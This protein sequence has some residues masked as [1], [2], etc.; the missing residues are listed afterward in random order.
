[1]KHPL[2]ASLL[3]D[4]SASNDL[5]DFLEGQ[6]TLFEHLHI[7]AALQN[8]PYRLSSPEAIMRVT[9]TGLAIME[10]RH[11]IIGLFG[12][13]KLPSHAVGLITHGIVQLAILQSTPFQTAVDDQIRDV[14]P[15]LPVGKKQ[16][17][18]QN[19][20]L[21]VEALADALMEYEFMSRVC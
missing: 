11:T 4:E 17:P 1:M 5:D 2:D 20:P 10:S 16:L 19:R 13:H 3:I 8:L 18:C 15:R 21:L 9:P 6:L 14:R 12:T 7:R